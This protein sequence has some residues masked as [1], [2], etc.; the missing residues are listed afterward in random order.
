[1]A[2]LLLLAGTRKGLLLARKRGRG[3]DVE[4]IALPMTAVYAVGI[5]ARGATPRLFA[6]AASEHWGPTILHSD[7]LGA[8]WSEPDRAPVAFPERT[9]AALARVWQIQPAGEDQPGVVYAGTE[10]TALFRSEDGGLTFEL[11]EALWDHP[12]RPQWAPGFGGQA[13]HTIVP[14]PGEPDRILIAM[15][16]GGVY[17]TQDGGRSWAPSN[18]GI[19]CTFLPDPYPEYGQCVHKV[20]PDSGD[21]N[22]LYLQNHNGVYRTDD[23]GATWSDIA[24]GLP[25]EFGF[26]VAADPRR[27]GRAYLFPLVSDGFRFPPDYRC[28]IYRTEDAGASWDDLSAGLPDDSFYSVVLRDALT[29][30]NAD[31]AGA[32]FGTRTGELYGCADRQ[33]ERIAGGL[34]DVLSVRAAA[35]A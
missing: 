4:S 5:D 30:D 1:M 26:A 12:H 2:D 3:W 9:G 33:W 25:G 14:Y 34:P 13:L 22:R 28:R 31:Q 7:D 29:T 16:G 19:K 6:A 35:L 24:R 20:A 10:P 11:N 23:W 17:R 27:S 8:T 21:P 15:S 32:Y 18:T